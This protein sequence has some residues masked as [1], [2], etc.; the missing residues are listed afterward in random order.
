MKRI[1]HIVTGYSVNMMTDE[2]PTD[3]L[4][5]CSSWSSYIDIIYAFEIPFMNESIE[6]K[7]NPN[8]F[9]LDLK[10]RK[11]IIDNEYIID[12]ETIHFGYS[13][14]ETYFKEMLDEF[15]INSNQEIVNDYINYGNEFIIDKHGYEFTYT[16]I[17]NNSI[18]F[19]YLMDIDQMKKW[20]IEINELF[21]KLILTNKNNSLEFYNEPN[22]KIPYITCKDLDQKNEFIDLFKEVLE[23]IQKEE[24]KFE[25]NKN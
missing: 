25:K 18:D 22:S 19:L 5:G 12:D 23:F 3:N 24:K 14:S 11:V 8:E 16:E 15:L 20:C 2:Y 4:F 7:T 17:L 13:L 10:N 1:T 6:F 21:Q 9:I